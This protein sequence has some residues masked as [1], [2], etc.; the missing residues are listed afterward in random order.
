MRDTSALPPRMQQTYPP[1]H[2]SLSRSQ[3]QLVSSQTSLIPPRHLNRMDGRPDAQADPS[4]RRQSQPPP[5]PG[6]TSFPNPHPL[7]NPHPTM[8]TEPGMHP[9][10]FT[11][12]RSQMQI[13]ADSYVPQASQFN[14]ETNSLYQSSL[15]SRND[16]S[17]SSISR[18]RSQN[19]PRPFIVSN[20]GPEPSYQ[21]TSSAQFRDKAALNSNVTVAK[22]SSADD[23]RF[24][25]GMAMLEEPETP[26]IPTPRIF[27]PHG[28]PDPAEEFNPYD[29]IH[30][31]NEHSRTS[32]PSA[33]TYDSSSH[34]SHGPGRASLRE[35]SRPPSPVRPLEVPKI[36]PAMRSVERP[37]KQHENP[38][39]ERNSV[40]PPPYSIAVGGNVTVVSDD[41]KKRAR[42]STYFHM[43]TETRASSPSTSPE[44][45][46]LRPSIRSGPS[47][48]SH[49]SHHSHRSNSE[50]PALPPMQPVVSQG[51]YP[52]IRTQDIPPGPQ[53][54]WRDPD[55]RAMQ[56]PS[57]QNGPPA[58][59]Q[60]QRSAPPDPPKVMPMLP[61]RR[62]R[63]RLVPSNM[64][65]P[66]RDPERDGKSTHQTISTTSSGQHRS[67]PPPR[68]HVP[69]H[70]VMPTP[71]NNANSVNANPS[72]FA[73]PHRVQPSSP[74]AHISS[75]QVPPRR[76][77]V[78]FQ[79]QA[80]VYYPPPSRSPLASNVY[81]SPTT[82]EL[83]DIQITAS[84]KLK[85]R[86][87]VVAPPSA[88]Q[89]PSPP[90]ITTVSFA[91]PVIGYGY[92]APAPVSKTVSRLKNEKIPKRVLSK[93]RTDL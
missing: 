47:D 62:S 19:M 33:L 32:S 80:H 52:T 24:D 28:T 27:L 56:S 6:F 21:T 22:E 82:K 75:R 78:A 10:D 92:P 73:T 7:P 77:Q 5:S 20:P 11:T 38:P 43:V 9:R 63:E 41:R 30:L 93:R 83:Q 1:V 45:V 74:P 2:P 51:V 25:I 67:G 13:P 90:V 49:Y 55:V 86:A 35:L 31:E 71:L 12:S 8:R 79:P 81:I 64:S 23:N 65:I 16:S 46:S 4:R 40:D 44:R 84:R 29:P 70:L 3:S 76:A 88:V 50:R 69:K 36:A 87:S 34:S 68:R 61:A 66:S 57:V 58:V 17:N 54:H 37:S 14:S 18:R 89:I 60:E 39:A 72:S 85:K 48:D 59:N 53:Q 91:P 42:Q 26:L 15:D